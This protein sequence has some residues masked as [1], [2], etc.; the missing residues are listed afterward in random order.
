MRQRRSFAHAP[1]V[2]PVGIAP[3]SAPFLVI[4]S[5]GMLPVFVFINFCLSVSA[6]GGWRTSHASPGSRSS[7]R[8]RSLSLWLRCDSVPRDS[9]PSSSAYAPIR[10][11]SAAGEPGKTA[12]MTCSPWL[13]PYAPQSEQT[14]QKFMK[15]KI[16]SLLVALFQR[17]SL[18]WP[19]FLV[20]HQLHMDYI[21]YRWRTVISMAGADC[22]ND[23][24]RELFAMSWPDELTRTVYAN[25]EQSGRGSLYNVEIYCRGEEHDTVLDL[26]WNGVPF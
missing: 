3:A 5:V 25:E 2:T 9:T 1:P 19:Q 16:L 22:A 14:D 20:R 18:P 4:G 26:M 15:T 10:W 7:L 17:T 11:A 21:S 13:P 23:A 12:G 6:P 8:L 24:E